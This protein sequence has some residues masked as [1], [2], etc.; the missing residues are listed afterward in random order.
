MKSMSH[1]F[2]LKTFYAMENDTH[3]DIFLEP[4]MGGDL[5]NLLYKT[6]KMPRNDGLGITNVSEKPT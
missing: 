3:F 1:V 4:M 2:L 6:K 5:W